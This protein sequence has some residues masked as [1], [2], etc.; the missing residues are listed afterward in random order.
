MSARKSKASAAPTPATE[1]DT[2]AAADVARFA[3][4]LQDRD[5]AE[6]QEQKQAGERRRA[7]A[8]VRQEAEAAQSRLDEARRRK[9]RA[10]RRA[11]DLRSRRAPADE[12]AAADAAY[13]AAL[14]DLEELETG[15]RPPWAP[16]STPADGDSAE[17]VVPV[18]DVP[19]DE[20]PA[21]APPA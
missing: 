13:R 21:S 5:R 1:A 12:V 17:G 10:V 19:A 7:E 18:D 15:S 2:D 8:E 11:K 14:A 16:P 3:A 6:R 9:D 4:F 20:A